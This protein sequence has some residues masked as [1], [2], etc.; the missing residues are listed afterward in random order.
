[1]GVTDADLQDSAQADAAPDARADGAQVEPPDALNCTRTGV[2]SAGRTY[3]ETTLGASAGLST[4]VRIADKTVTRG[5]ARLV[6][7]L[8][9]DG[10]TG[11][12]DDSA[13]RALLSWADTN[14]ARVVSALAPNGCS[15]S[16][17]LGKS[18]ANSTYES[19]SDGIQANYLDA[20]LTELA[21]RIQLANAPIFVES[22]SGGSIFVSYSF[23]PKF[24][25]KY[26]GRYAINCGGVGNPLML[27]FAPASILSTTRFDFTYG[28]QDFLRF[29][30][31]A[32]TL[33][34][35][36]K[37]FDVREA[38]LPGIGHCLFDVHAR[39]A[40]VFSAP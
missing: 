15:W 25:N 28:D 21:T 39:A 6:L 27:S 32:S 29:D 23:F 24:G 22:V 16:Q 19:D 13:M 37:G 10:A 18:C 38:I 12:T 7:F 8:H 40:Q 30:A 2:L 26:P 33:Y 1:M 20:A 5:P 17:A 34:Y 9:A 4:I 31:H 14:N 3:C 35:Q 36:S 11:Y